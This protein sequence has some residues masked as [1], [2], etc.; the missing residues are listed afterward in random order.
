LTWRLSLGRN[1]RFEINNSITLEKRI[2]NRLA[3]LETK[4]MLRTL[5]SP[6]GIDLSSNDYLGLAKHP[7]LVDHLISALQQ[8]GCG[9]TGSR[10]LR[11]H[12]E[13]FTAVEQCF[14]KFKRTARS[15][16][17]S[18]G[19]LA[20]IA[21]L[22]TL[23]EAG[24]VVYSDER[25]HASLID[26]LRLSQA[27]CVVFPH[28]DVNR[29]ADHLSNGRR[30]GQ[31]F[32]VVESLF[33]MNGDFA[34][35]VDYVSLCRKYN[36]QLIVDEAHAVG[37]YGSGGNGLIDNAGVSTDVLVSINTAGKA[38]GVAGA[39]V[40]GTDWA[41]DYLEQR[42]RPFMFSTA[43]PPAF[44]EALIVSLGIITSEPER[45]K[46]LFDRVRFLRKQLHRL[47]ISIPS[48]ESQIIPILVGK[49]SK[50]VSLASKM[51][52][53]GFDVRAIRPPSVPEG[54]ALL[55]VSVNADLSEENLCRFVETLNKY[56]GKEE[57]CLV[58]S[59]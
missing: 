20:N 15:L 3:E 31:R 23:P 17:F 41:I 47:N 49:N 56:L 33:S 53:D 29:L 21:V 50:A 39:F 1:R 5:C 10:L 7:K 22:T 19:Y 40:S 27:D 43:P 38:L 2:R 25:N 55:R 52:K 6:E 16:Y 35:L 11:G 18:S 48:D 26:G 30:S 42:A 57:S 54:Q 13:S 9:S 4:G 14:S 24:D 8:E 32:I 44:T 36:A 37:I 59:L 45:R 46:R 28:N 12:R 58:D 51:Q 34:P